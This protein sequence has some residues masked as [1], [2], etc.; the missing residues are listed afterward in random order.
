VLTLHNF[1]LFCP[2]AIPM[3]EDRVCTEC[4]DRHGV[5]PALRHGC[6][7]NSFAATLPLAT[8]V[9]LHRMLGTWR[10]DVDTF[11]AL[12]DFQRKLMA[13]AGLPEEKIAVKPNFYP[14]NPT[15]IPMSERGEPYVA[16][17]GR[18]SKEKGVPALVEAWK[19]WGPGAPRLLIVGDGPLRGWIEANS[20]GANIELTG[21]LPAAAAQARIAQARLVI[22]PSVWFECFPMVVREAFAF[23]TP[24]AVSDIGP[25]PS[26]VRDG[27]SGIV[28]QPGDAA[29]LLDKVRGALADPARLERLGQAGRAE[30]ERLY[31][32]EVNFR[33]L[34]EIYGRA[35][36]NNQK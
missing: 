35:I 27:V 33:L 25:L 10:N 34:M 8:N 23:G 9:A 32:E 18:L 22:L 7:R 20:S 29:S 2:A 4:I 31:N 3:R 26:I 21:L 6:Y 1:R 28:F 11:I 15:P 5:L 36:A 12:S 16:F 14:G 17:V 13:K 30:F 24:M 19:L